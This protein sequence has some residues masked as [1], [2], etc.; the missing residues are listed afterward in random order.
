MRSF[1]MQFEFHYICNFLG[2]EIFKTIKSLQAAISS[3]QRQDVKLGFV[4]TMGALHE[5]HI[6]LINVCKEKQDIPIASIYVN[7]T[8]FNDP[9]D[10]KNYPR[11]F[12]RDLNMLKKAG[13]RYTFIPDDKEM[14]PIPDTR[15][16]DFG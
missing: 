1:F 15:V 16:F 14:Y 10:L 7:P 12:K 11:N 8:Q 4:P 2:M 6:S 9:D 13:C 3:I 5:G